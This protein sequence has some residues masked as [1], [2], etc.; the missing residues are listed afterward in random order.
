MSATETQARASQTSTGTYQRAGERSM[1]SQTRSTGTAV[2]VWSGESTSVCVPGPSC[3]ASMSP[4]ASS[5][6]VSAGRPR[7]RPRARN[8]AASTSRV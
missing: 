8:A 7:A 4:A 1:S 6:R 3:G 5:A 2:P